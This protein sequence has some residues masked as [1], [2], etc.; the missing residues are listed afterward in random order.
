MDAE[1]VDLERKL[2][3]VNHLPKKTLEAEF[4]RC[5]GSRAWGQA[6][7]QKMPFTSYNSL[8]DIASLVWWN[9]PVSEWQMAFSAHPQIGMFSL[10]S[11]SFTKSIGLGV[12]LYAM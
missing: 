10:S 11:C 6:M 5:C 12:K 8:L 7:I 3:E 2:F 4:L 9:L 1:A